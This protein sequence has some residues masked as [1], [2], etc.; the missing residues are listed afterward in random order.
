MKKVI[1][2]GFLLVVIFM[3]FGIKAFADNG[4]DPQA[5]DKNGVIPQEYGKLV[6]VRDNY[7]YF[8]ANDGTIRI[9][10]IAVW[11]GTT[12]YISKSMKIEIKRK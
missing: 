6:Q 4:Y 3:L 1:I 2:V 11:D 7:L 9:I 8:E 12:Y 5:W 10:E